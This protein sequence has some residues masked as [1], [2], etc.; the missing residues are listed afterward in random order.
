MIPFFSVRKSLP[1]AQL[2]RSL[3]RS[4]IS[5]WATFR[6]PFSARIMGSW[7][8]W[9]R[10]ED[11]LADTCALAKARCTLLMALREV[12]PKLFSMA[13]SSNSCLFARL[14]A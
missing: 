2:F 8:P 3:L 7:P 14:F 12:R 9:F 1:A 4:S 5:A 6:A 10:A 13:R 11:R